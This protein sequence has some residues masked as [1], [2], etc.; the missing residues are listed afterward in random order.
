MLV[1][2]IGKKDTISS[3][4]DKLY[5]V[6]SIERGWYR[7]MTVLDEDY[8]F[9][10]EAFEI[11]RKRKA[12]LSDS[13]GESSREK[14]A[15]WQ[16]GDIYERCSWSAFLWIHLEPMM[17]QT[18]VPIRTWNYRSRW[19]YVVADLFPGTSYPM[20]F[21]WERHTFPCYGWHSFHCLQAC[22]DNSASVKRPG[23]KKPEIARFQG[24]PV[25]RIS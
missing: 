18:F 17:I 23:L 5:T 13:L 1:R 16:D 9:P 8:L 15:Y 11:V 14:N 25:V 12:I 6:L 4:R 2:Y 22:W 7:I 21:S 3:D 10:P 20:I 24:I 19:G